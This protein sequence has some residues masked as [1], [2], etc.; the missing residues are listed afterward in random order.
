MEIFM[1]I[2]KIISNWGYWILLGL[3]LFL[4]GLV[5]SINIIG[6]SG[7]IV[8]VLTGIVAVVFSFINIFKKKKK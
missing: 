4:I 7:L 8:M 5:F 6:T 2:K 1:E 3:A